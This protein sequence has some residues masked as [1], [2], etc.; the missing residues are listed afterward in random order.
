MGDEV[1]ISLSVEQDFYSFD[2]IK[3]QETAIKALR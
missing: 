1:P 3:Q 2:N